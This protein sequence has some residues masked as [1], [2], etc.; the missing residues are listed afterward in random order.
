M[1]RNLR[2]LNAR[3]SLLAGL[4]LAVLPV[5]EGVQHNQKRRNYMQIAREYSKK[6]GMNRHG[7]RGITGKGFPAVAAASGDNEDSS[8][9]SSGSDSDSDSSSDEEDMKEMRKNRFLSEGSYKENVLIN[10]ED[11]GRKRE[12]VKTNRA[13]KIPR[14]KK[15]YFSVVKYFSQFN[16]DTFNSGNIYSIPSGG[17]V[18]LDRDDL[19][20]IIPEGSY[21]IPYSNDLFTHLTHVRTIR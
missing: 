15:E 18:Q 3:S 4:K 21:C 5:T 14:P 10:N 6:T 2:R 17:Y 9:S 12:E 7:R 20:K 16:N 1:L 8:S 11:E 13:H 19:S